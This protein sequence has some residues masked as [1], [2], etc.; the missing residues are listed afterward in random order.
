MNRSKALK[1][2]NLK[3]GFSEEEVKKA[4]RQKAMECH[5]D[6]N[7]N[8]PKSEELFKEINSAYECLTKHPQGSS[9]DFFGGSFSGMSDL[10]DFL[11]QLHNFTFN[12][13][14]NQRRRQGTGAKKPA[15]YNTVIP[16]DHINLGKVNVSLTTVLL[17]E[18]L[19]LHFKIKSICTHCLTDQKS[20][21]PC[22]TCNQLGIVI[23]NTRTPIGVLSQTHQCNTCK[24]SGWNKSKHCKLCK[25]RLFLVK[26]KEIEVTISDNFSI[27]S[28][29]EIIN[30]GNEGWGCPVTNVY[31]EPKLILPKNLNKLTDSEKESFHLLLS[32]LY[33][34]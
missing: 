8:D 7:K 13:H 14:R 26:E 31:L 27:N 15:P 33:S 3:E 11:N 22:T 20:W 23:I 6:R 34:N 25:D 9:D 17:K 4:Y 5:P 12:Q 19:K 21:V 16:F 1:L 30:Q 10:N 28:P 2:L 18:P 24:G 32:K 29:V